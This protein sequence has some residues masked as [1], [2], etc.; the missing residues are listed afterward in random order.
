MISSILAWDVEGFCDFVK[1]LW[2]LQG[3]QHLLFVSGSTGA[4]RH[5][6]FEASITSARRDKAEIGELGEM[7]GINV[8]A[9]SF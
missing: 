4:T 6:A 1:I 7:L 8:M 2:N 3:P 5:H 9:W